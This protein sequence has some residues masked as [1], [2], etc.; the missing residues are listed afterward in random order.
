ML[1]KGAALVLTDVSEEFGPKSLRATFRAAI[2]LGQYR[3]ELC[4]KKAVGARVGGRLA[5][6][7]VHHILSTVW[8]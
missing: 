3:A 6:S 8:I 1:N 2:A 4:S 5:M 7:E